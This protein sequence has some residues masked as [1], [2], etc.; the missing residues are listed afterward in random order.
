[1]DKG[2]DFPTDAFAEILLR[3]PP[4][5]RRRLR[6]VCRHWREVIDER[7]PEKRSRPK[8]L[9]F[10]SEL[11]SLSAYVIDDLPEGPC[12]KVWTDGV[13]SGT[14]RRTEPVGTCNGLLCLYEVD[15]IKPSGTISLVNPVT[16]ETLA[17]PQLPLSVDIPTYNWIYQAYSFGYV[18]T[19]GLYK[20]MHIP[21]SLDDTAQFIVVQ[22]LTLGEASWRNIPAPAGASCCLGSG[23]I[24]VDGT[25]H[26]VTKDTVRLAS[27]DLADESFASTAPLPVPT[28]PGYTTRLT[29]VRGRLGV[30]SSLSKA[31]PAKIEVWVLGDGGRK[32]QQGWSRRYR[33]QVRGMVER[34][35]PRPQF[36]HGDYA[37][38]AESKNYTDIVVYGHTRSGAARRSQCHFARISEQ[39]PVACIKG[40][41]RCMFAYI[42]TTEPLGL[43]RLRD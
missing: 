18:P 41:L 13:V 42:E 29:V 33:V 30:T 6:L 26:W 21:C 16:G 3:L 14:D 36:A 2:S 39:K 11:Y 34:F 8:A 19:T 5:S 9:V 4:S 35:L 20:I 7:A 43:Y 22:V 28:G 10:V 15:R 27:F 1:M 12:R 23:I 40:N 17:V 37:L 24:V 38:T 25:A 32:D 31:T